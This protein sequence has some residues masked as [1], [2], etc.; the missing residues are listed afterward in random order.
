MTTPPLRQST[1]GPNLGFHQFAAIRRGVVILPEVSPVRII[2]VRHAHVV[3]GHLD[4]DTDR[5][6]SPWG[7]EVAAQA[8]HWLRARG[9]R[10]GLVITTR[11]ARTRETASITL[12]VL[13][14]SPEEIGWWQQDS[15]PR[16]RRGWLRLTDS[17]RLVLPPDGVVL[18]VGHGTTQDLLVG[19]SPPLSISTRSRGACL[20]MDEVGPD[21]WRCVDCWPGLADE[22]RA[23]AGASLAPFATASR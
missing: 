15:L 9:L 10:P 22:R 11:V 1:R 21:V 2:Y 8:G 14:F 18:V 17:L 16:D 7:R 19:M 3:P 23:G 13:G 12:H 5:P 6:L 20:V 4:L